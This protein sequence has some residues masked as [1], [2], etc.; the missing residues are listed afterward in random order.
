[1]TKYS[2]IP[3]LRHEIEGLN[4]EISTFTRVLAEM[5]S[6][7]TKCADLIKLLKQSRT[8]YMQRHAE[9]VRELDAIKAD[10]QEV[11]E[12]IYFHDLKN[13]TWEQA[14]NRLSAG[15]YSEAPKHYCIHVVT[16]YLEKYGYVKNES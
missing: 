6:F 1:M 13:F 16:R 5:P 10:N 3:F 12:M 8:E 11:Y 14:F 9:L 7:K 2:D 4:T 15:I